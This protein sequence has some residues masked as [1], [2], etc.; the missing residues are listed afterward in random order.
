[1][2]ASI[3]RWQGAIATW[4]AGS[5]NNAR[6]R[7]WFAKALVTMLIAVRPSIE[8]LLTRIHRMLGLTIPAAPDDELR[9]EL[10]ARLD[11]WAIDCAGG[12]QKAALKGSLGVYG[13]IVRHWP[14]I[15]EAFGLTDGIDTQ[16]FKWLWARLTKNGNEALRP[17]AFR[18]L[19]DLG[20]G[21]E[22]ADERIGS[23]QVDT[24]LDAPAGYQRMNDRAASP[25]RRL[26]AWVLDP[27]G[28][29]G[30][31]LLCGVRGS[32]KSRFVQDLEGP[33]LRAAEVFASEPYWPLVCGLS[34]SSGMHT[35]GDVL[36]DLL[37]ALASRADRRYREAMGVMGLWMRPL[38]ALNSGVLHLGHYAHRNLGWHSALLGLLL[39]VLILVGF[40]TAPTQA[41]AAYETL[42]A[43][44][45]VP[46]RLPQDLN[47]LFLMIAS[48]IALGLLL[49]GLCYRLRASEMV[50]WRWAYWE[51]FSVLAVIVLLCLRL[52]GLA[53]KPDS[54]SNGS[55]SEPGMSAV[56]VQWGVLVV[57]LLTI[58]IVD[59]VLWRWVKA[60][61]TAF[62]EKSGTASSFAPG[63]PG[64]GSRFARLDWFVPEL[65]GAML[66][67]AAVLALV[68]LSGQTLF[69]LTWGWFPTDGPWVGFAYVAALFGIL[70]A[71]LLLLPTARY[72]LANLRQ[73][74]TQ[75]VDRTTAA[76]AP[77]PT[78]PFPLG[79]YV[80]A[81]LPRYG[82]H[83]LSNEA[84][85]R[86][87]QGLQKVM[88]T[89]QRLFGRIVVWIDDV[90]ILPSDKYSTVLR[91]LRPL[92]KA[93]NGVVAIVAAPMSFY[94]AFKL[95]APNDVHSSV[96]DAIVLAPKALFVS[97]AQAF[98]STEHAQK[99]G[100]RSTRRVFAPGSIMVDGSRLALPSQVAI[101]NAPDSQAPDQGVFAIQLLRATS[102]LPLLPNVALHQSTA[103]AWIVE[104]DKSLF[105]PHAQFKRINALGF[106]IREWKRHIERCLKGPVEEEALESG[107]RDRFVEVDRL[108]ETPGE[109]Y[110]CLL[111][112]LRAE[113]LA[114]AALD[115]QA[116]R[117]L[118][119]VADR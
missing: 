45:L 7:A 16:T 15:A 77:A 40:F 108:A 104:R 98:A 81:L 41:Y 1:M 8:W 14:E 12:P 70:A 73:L 13:R 78:A 90:D 105:D 42:P 75:I 53:I 89:L 68:A 106:S 91:A 5:S 55:A 63:L 18:M 103:V 72:Q 112:T 101:R 36:C 100:R 60:V 54:N 99:Q 74:T 4:Q 85:A 51:Q 109:S 86:A 47:V 84:E 35:V 61:S 28:P 52:A 2:P 24:V 50:P 117:A 48:A 37:R 58:A 71:W 118:P 21:P 3:A 57:G 66:G 119:R 22:D 67:I 80:K 49:I 102:R 25:L 6:L 76:A 38:L 27:D 107:A 34:I 39:A 82:D 19:F 56:A 17:D 10:H 59:F 9:A 93:G 94:H 88:R 65:L 116:L 46:H 79:E 113:A 23:C 83:E 32:G 115:H 96:R 33:D 92:T 11:A 97:A 111:D 20:P 87:Q 29:R 26:A 44:M 69:V 95:K 62:N 64:R 114:E 31:Y 30:V 110:Q 43:L